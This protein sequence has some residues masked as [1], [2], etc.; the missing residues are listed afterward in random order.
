MV[1]YCERLLLLG[2]NS[3]NMKWGGVHAE[4]NSIRVTENIIMYF[5]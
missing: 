2:Y 3:E 4:C 1:Q 5:V